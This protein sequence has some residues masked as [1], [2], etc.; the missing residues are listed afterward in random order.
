MA[1]LA[2]RTESDVRMAIA[3]QK[4]RLRDAR[5]SIKELINDVKDARTEADKI[6]AQ[7]D[8]LHENARKLVEEAKACQS[9]RDEI[10]KMAADLRGKKRK[11]TSELKGQ[12]DKMVSYKRERQALNRSAGASREALVKQLNGGVK[13]LLGMDMA[14]KNEA[15]LFEMVF[16]W[17]DRLKLKDKADEVHKKVQEKWD[18]KSEV[19]EEAQA[20][21]EEIGRLIEASNHEH[22]ES[23]RLFQE[24]DEA[25]A[26][27]NEM[28]EK[29]ISKKKELKDI[30]SSINEAKAYADTI[31]KKLNEL[32][33]ELTKMVG[34]KRA[35]EDQRKFEGAKQKMDTGSKLS[36]DELKV[37]LDK[38]ALK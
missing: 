23:V 19:E 37:L 20:L 12:I 4:S 22:A 36:M 9:R 7:R 38:G 10:N 33:D 31:Q 8:L 34:R 1:A 16:E 14:L 15:V 3:E 26:Q 18:E 5:A 35:R 25:R 27:A 21:Y 28:H 30:Q 6:A 29:W 32:E 17:R 11:V 24:K 13:T 2:D